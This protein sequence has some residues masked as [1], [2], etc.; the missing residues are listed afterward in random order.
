MKRLPFGLAKVRATYPLVVL[1]GT[2]AFM[3]FLV[4]GSMPSVRAQTITGTD[5]VLT[6]PQG[7]ITAR[8]TTSGEG[9]PVLFF[10]DSRNTVRLSVGLYADGTPSVV[11]DDDS[12]RASAIL[13]LVQNNGN[14]V[15]VLKENGQDKLVINKNGL[16]RQQLPIAPSLGSGFAA[17]LIGGLLAAA[18][19]RGRSL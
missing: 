12:G 5:F 18:F 14:P 11:L 9:S 16:P 17:G 7:N 8:L 4:I 3:I 13:R 2:V 19:A 10:Y 6:G 1:G 15:L